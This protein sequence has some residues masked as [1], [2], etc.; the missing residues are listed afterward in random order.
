MSFRLPANQSCAGYSCM[1]EIDFSKLEVPTA[2][3]F[4][5]TQTARSVLGRVKYY[6]NKFV[7]RCGNSR[8]NRCDRSIPGM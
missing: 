7:I 4:L 2:E 3:A 5:D 6:G 1:S 8:L